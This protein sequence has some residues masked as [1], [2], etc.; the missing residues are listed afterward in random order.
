MGTWIER[1]L[2]RGADP[3]IVNNAGS[4]LLTHNENHTLA[5]KQALP[6]MLKHG[7]NLTVPGKNDW[8]LLFDALEMLP[9]D[10]SVL[11]S[12][13]ESTFQQLETAYASPITRNS[14]PWLPYWHHAAKAE[15]WEAARDLVL[16]SRDLVP[17]KI[18]GKLVRSTL[19]AMAGRHIQRLRS[20]SGDEED[21]KDKRRRC[22]AVVLRDCREQGIASEKTHLDYLLEL[23]I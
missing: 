8:P 15:S 12:L 10:D 4:F 11:K 13:V 14:G 18:E 23:C 19:G 17:A 6:A 9:A 16:R 3:N 22:L 7:G 5:V 2:K 20:M 21:L 1:L